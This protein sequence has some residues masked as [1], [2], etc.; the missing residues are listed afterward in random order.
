MPSPTHQNIQA[1]SGMCIHMFVGQ[2]DELGFDQPMRQQA[3]QFRKQGLAVTF[4]VEPG[5]PHQIESLMY[6]GSARLFDQFDRDQ[7][8]CVRDR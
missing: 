5:Q 4:S 6:A 7:R 1:I 8:A 2:N 3:A